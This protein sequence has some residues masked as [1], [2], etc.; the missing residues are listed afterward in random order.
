MDMNMKGSI[1]KTVNV[2]VKYGMIMMSAWKMWV[3]FRPKTM[4]K[5]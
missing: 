5:S 3:L 2:G 1:G 4:E